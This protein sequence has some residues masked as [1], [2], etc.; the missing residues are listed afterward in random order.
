[1]KKKRSLRDRIIIC[2]ICV[3]RMDIDRNSALNIM[4]KYL[5]LKR[6]ENLLHQPSVKYEPILDHWNGFVMIKNLFRIKSRDGL[7]KSPRA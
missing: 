3:K 2:D 5:Y 6:S 4:K 7:I 1:M